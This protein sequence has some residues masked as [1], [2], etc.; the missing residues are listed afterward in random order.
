MLLLFLFG[1]SGWLEERNERKERT[2]KKMNDNNDD[3]NHTH[4]HM[5]VLNIAARNGSRFISSLLCPENTKLFS[6]FF[7]LF[8]LFPPLAGSLASPFMLCCAGRT[9]R[10][11][12]KFGEFSLLNF[13]HARWCVRLV[14]LSVLVRRKCMCLCAYLLYGYDGLWAYGNFVR[15]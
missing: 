12:C 1:S 8:S 7:I 10:N 6:F 3:C 2:K 5:F 14:R 15:L 9:F 11:I 13:A 4:S